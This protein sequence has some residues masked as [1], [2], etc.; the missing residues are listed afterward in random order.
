MPILYLPRT[1][2]K[3]PLIDFIPDI[4]EESQGSPFTPEAEGVKI[5]QL[6]ASYTDGR[7]QNPPAVAVR[8]TPSS[9]IA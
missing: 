3:A 7:P 6:A 4:V 8:I 5:V 9:S 1:F 2:A